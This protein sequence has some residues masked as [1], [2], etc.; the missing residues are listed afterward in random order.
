MQRPGTE[1]KYNINTMDNKRRDF[2]GP[3][4]GTT[5]AAVITNKIYELYSSFES[6]EKGLGLCAISNNKS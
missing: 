3:P 5:P 1:V 2:D 4:H 6:T